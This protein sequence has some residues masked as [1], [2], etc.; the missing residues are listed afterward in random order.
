MNLRGTLGN[1]FAI[2]P[3]TI[4]RCDPEA[5]C[6][7]SSFSSKPF[8]LN[9]FLKLVDSAPISNFPDGGSEASKSV[10][11]DPF[12]DTVMSSAYL[13]KTTRFNFEN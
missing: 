9:M 3:V 13:V 12:V 4:F 8:W 1:S 7:F 10:T 5:K 6:I 2:S 11:G